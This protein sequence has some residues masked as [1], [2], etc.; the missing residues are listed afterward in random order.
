MSETGH[1]KNISNFELLIDA[2]TSFGA[3]YQPANGIIALKHLQ[4]QHTA[5]ITATADVTEKLI[6]WKVSVNDRE[7]VYD[8]I[9]RFM[10]RFAGAFAACG[11]KP[12]TIADMRGY[13]R[14]IAGER[15]GKLKV[16]DPSTPENEAAH[17]SVS[18]RSYA[19]VAE[20]FASAVELAASEPLY[21]PNEDDL[22]IP[23]LEARVDSMKD[24]NSAVASSISTLAIQ[25]IA[26]NVV[27]YTADDCIVALAKLVKL[28]VKSVYGQTSPQYKLIS[29]I[30]FTKPA[31]V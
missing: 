7:T 4:D 17:N 3:D 15:K 20:H 27:L 16:D 5:A 10:T 29:R 14:K 24:V 6:D 13:Q 26:R 28:Y 22:K 18:Q 2:V 25:R 21:Q 9:G 23:A 1:A 12:N 11:A 8:G 31:G 19:S 30:T